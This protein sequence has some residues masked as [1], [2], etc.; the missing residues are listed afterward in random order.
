MLFHFLLGYRSYDQ[1]TARQSRAPRRRAQQRPWARLAVEALE[2]RTLL[3]TFVVDRLTDSGAGSGLSG[4]LR[5]CIANAVD[6]DN[7]TFDDGV[8]GTIKLTGAL[9]VPHSVSIQGPGANLLTV[10]PVTGY[11]DS[12]FTVT[13]GTTVSIAGLTISGA[14]YGIDDRGALTLNNSTLS[15][16]TQGICT[17]YASSSLTVTLNSSTISGNVIGINFNHSGTHT[18]NN[19]TVGG[20]SQGGIEIGS[21]GTAT[22][23]NCTIRGNGGS[24]AGYGGGIYI[25][26]GCTLTLN[27]S[28]VSGN[29]VAS[30]G[31]NGGVGGGIANGGTLTLNNSTVSG[32]SVLSVSE[33]GGGGG[34]IASSG[35]LTLNNST[36]SGNSVPAYGDSLGDGIYS[37]VT[38]LR[39]TIIAG[40]GH[41]QDL[42]ANVTSQGH[43]LIGNG[44]DSSGFGDTDLVGTAAAPIDA[45]LGPLQDNGGPTQTMALLPGSPALNAGDPA[46]LGVADQR[47]VVRSG[48]V[49]IGAYQASASVFVLTAPATATAGTAFNLTVKAVDTFGQ[50]AVG[51][52]GT[53]QFT[54]SDGQA[55]LPANYTFTGTDAGLH[56]FSNG[57]TLKTACTRTVT[58]SDTATSSITGTA[59]VSVNPAAADHLLFL[60]QPTDTAAGQTMTP[61]VTVAVVDQFGNVVTSD[62]SDTVT[63]AI[64]ANPGG[65]TLSG[66]LTVTV[67]NGVAT[68]SD[69]SIDLAGDG[70][71][72]HAMTTGLADAESSAFR[73]TA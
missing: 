24:F 59:S 40:N 2:D 5:Y 18:M 36:V 47:G 72:L 7:I 52:T 32:N 13:N 71:T 57:V 29:S 53:V 27:N 69:L 9:S 37:Y 55:V 50:T 4:D 41:G 35:T 67:V 38:T 45:R 61:V 12:I 63:L 22:L 23:N 73:I 8:T 48:G 15:G 54:S 6:N 17:Y 43:N 19:C 21:G 46:Q 34:G 1:E 25:A 62:N 16:N 51:Y 28:T 70:Y 31:E 64:G 11:F 10:R 66:T 49:N 39:N 44:S 65:G 42:V 58:A 3:S 14:I 30:D 56:T 60:Q 20:N 26:N 33:F 68:F